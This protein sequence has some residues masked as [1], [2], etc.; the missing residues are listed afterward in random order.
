MEAVP[1][2]TRIGAAALGF[3]ITL[4]LIQAAEL[5]AQIKTIKVDVDPSFASHGLLFVDQSANGFQP[6]L[7]NMAGSYYTQ[8]TP[9]IPY[10]VILYNTNPSRVT[11]VVMRYPRKDS[12]GAVIQGTTTN[13]VL[14][15]PTGTTLPLILSP[16]QA[17]SA[18]LN[19]RGKVRP[20]DVTPFMGNMLNNLDPQRFSE[21]TISPDLVMFEDGGYVGPNR[22]G[23]LEVE[24]GK[25]QY[26]A[27]RLSQFQDKTISDADLRAQLTAIAQQ[28]I[29][30]PDKLRNFNTLEA[31]GILQMWDLKSSRAE[32]AEW[33]SKL[34]AS[35]KPAVG[36]FHRLQ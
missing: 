11:T 20:A 35:H 30:G 10:T 17:V 21:V 3:G 18:V 32:M 2:L 19:T 12:T 25:A 36:S 23:I 8:I 1:R 9:L 31:R 28:S 4:A 5:H 13:A 34:I 24:E 6:A 15:S 16:D 29:G 22:A 27:D 33:Y 7:Q 26:A 14:P